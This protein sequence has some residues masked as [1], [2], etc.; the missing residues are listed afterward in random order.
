MEWTNRGDEN[1]YDFELGDL[2]ADGDWHDIDLS[3]IISAGAKLVL[4][5]L[6]LN[7]GTAGYF[8]QFRTKGHTSACAVVKV[9]TNAAS[10]LVY[11]SICVQPDSDGIIQYET[12][13]AVMWLQTNMR[14]MGWLS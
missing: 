5:A 7:H 8:M 3:G 6:E 13:V 12:G 11:T 4:L 1:V 14:V 10:R 2:E 9:T